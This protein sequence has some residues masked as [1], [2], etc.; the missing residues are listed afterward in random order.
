VSHGGVVT[1]S[2][3]SVGTPAEAG[4]LCVWTAHGP[5]Y[6]SRELRVL[7]TECEVVAVIVVHYDLPSTLPPYR[8]RAALK[9]ASMPSP[10]PSPS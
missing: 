7:L 8:S 9:V 2:T 10:R 6:R 3:Y 1:G 4:P 5:V